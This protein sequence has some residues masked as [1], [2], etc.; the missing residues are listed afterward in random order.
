M[1]IVAGE[2]LSPGGLDVY[3]FFSHGVLV[4]AGEAE[5]RDR[6]YE[7]F[8]NAAS[9]GIVAGAAHS[10]SDG[11]VQGLLV[12]GRLVMAAKTKVRHGSREFRR[13]FPPVMVPHMARTAP[14]LDRRVHGLSHSLVRMTVEALWFRGGLWLR[15]VLRLRYVLLLRSIHRAGDQE[16]GE[17]KTEEWEL[18]SH[19][20]NCSP[21]YA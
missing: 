14:H 6:G 17:N 12:E 5:V 13:G 15:G 2:A 16:Q 1:R 4:V 3:F 19:G 10:T 18:S 20:L 8:R 7:Q 21:A 11:S 9:M